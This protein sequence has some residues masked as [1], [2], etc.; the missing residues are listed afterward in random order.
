MT[1]HNP[2]PIA[3]SPIRHNTDL[4]RFETT[5]NLEGTDYT[6]YISYRLNDEQIIYDHTIVP[7][8]LGGRGIGSILVKH[9]LDYADAEDKKVVPEC[10][11]VEKYIDKH[12]AYQHLLA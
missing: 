7:K 1:N 4:N 8:Q 11:F 12:P 10:W 3:Q 2:Q 5:I 6:A 9:A